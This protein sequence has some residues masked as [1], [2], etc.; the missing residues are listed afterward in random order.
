M[1]V[2]VIAIWTAPKARVDEVRD[3]LRELAGVTLTEEGCLRF[4]VWEADGL[5][6]RFVLMEEYLGES[7][8]LAHLA[9]DYFTRLVLDRAVGLRVE[10]DV[11]VHRQVEPATQSSRRR[12]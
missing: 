6:G 3:L 12:R 11:R 10:R 9:T 8:R 7:A 4:E 2:H 5:P 1:S